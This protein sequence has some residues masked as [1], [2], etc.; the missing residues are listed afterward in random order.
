MKQLLILP[1]LLFL[2]GI[3]LIT[4][5]QNIDDIDG[6]VNIADALKHPNETIRV[7]IT[8]NKNEVKLLM[9]NCSSFKNLSAFKIKDAT[10]ETDW[11]QL[12]VTLSK[13]PIKEIEL[14]FNEI[15]NVPGAIAN[16]KNLEKLVIWGSPDLNYSNLFKNLS[17]LTNLKALE[18]NGNEIENVP[19]ELKLLKNLE[20]FTITDNEAI[21]Y[22]DLIDK[23]TALPALKN[24]SLEVN[25]LTELPPNIAKLKNLTK[26]NI[27]NNY[28]ANLPDEMA[29]LINLDSLDVSGNLI[30]NYVDEFNKLKGIDINYF[31]VEKGL[32]E[33]EKAAILNLFPNATI[34]E[35]TNEADQEQLIEA[36]TQ[37][38]ILKNQL[39]Q[40][41]VPELNLPTQ[42]F[43]INSNVNSEIA[44]LSGTQIRIPDA[45]FVDRNNE[46]VTG[47]VTISYREFSNP[48]DIAFSGIP[49]EYSNDSVYYPMVSAGMFEIN[50]FQNNQP[51]LIKKGKE[52]TVDL[53]SN[54]SSDS[55]NLYEIDTA[56]KSW[57]D[58]GKQGTIKIAKPKSDNASDTLN[59]SI[60]NRFIPS[61]PNYSQ[62][63][64]GTNNIVNYNLGYRSGIILSTVWE[65][66]R[67]LLRKYD[68]TSFDT[69]FKDPSFCYQSQYFNNKYNRYLNLK[70]YTN[71]NISLEKEECLFR[72]EKLAYSNTTN[73]ELNIFGGII[74]ASEGGE[75]PKE[76]RKKYIR[77]KKYSDIRIERSDERF[78]LKLK[79]RKEIISIP[80]HPF[81]NSKALP[82]KLQ[83]NYDRRYRDYTKI[84]TRRKKSFNKNL[85][86]NYVK[87]SSRQQK[88]FNK[89]I[90][91]NREKYC[92]KLWMNLKPKMSKKERKLTY[93]QWKG[94]YTR[95]CEMFPD[96]L[97]KLERNINRNSSA[98]VQQS[99]NYLLSSITGKTQTQAY[100][101]PVAIR[102][103]KLV[104]LGTWNCDHPPTAREIIAIKMA[105]MPKK[106]INGFIR[107]CNVTLAAPST[108]VK[109]GNNIV[110]AVSSLN[111]PKLYSTIYANYTDKQ[112]N[113]LSPSKVM[114]IDKRINTVADL[115]NGTSMTLAVN[116]TK[117]LFAVMGDGSVGLFS[118]DDFK[119]IDLLD[120]TNFTFPLTM[121]PQKDLGKLREYLKY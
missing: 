28:I 97:A 64:L 79:D 34:D 87:A 70:I 107:A 36:T 67:D 19:A 85:F 77:N 37:A 42:T 3:P 27:S 22:V 66:Y 78:V 48:F 71:E 9:D 73:P 111:D 63:S 120:K 12:F 7:G 50:A 121:Y 32:S 59:T 41:I 35:K 118:E 20:S 4:K 108:I 95:L 39:F 33:A 72:V 46:P 119:K 38:T 81:N 91:T 76:F 25:E 106:A 62:N 110:N 57:K 80:V 99:S 68:T 26:L 98:E 53:A 11:S 89:N 58:L 54:D 10:S 18:L 14:T 43:V 74:W 55:Y 31:S 113:R 69:R 5:A 23:L 104:R 112:N 13:Q 49:M 114:V 116:S 56:T 45:T 100:K 47:N 102:Q 6:Y 84:L 65:Q 60:S 90:C 40:P 86:C 61:N 103:I 96:S 88:K 105:N 101:T 8:G 16:F 83:K 94:Y 93:D 15:K 117:N 82:E 30:V 17:G 52:I 115:G 51:L 109:T 44:L 75:T 29:K 24:L 2:L 1:L 21:N 92:Y